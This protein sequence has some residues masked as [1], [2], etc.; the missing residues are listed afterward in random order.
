MLSTWMWTCMRLWMHPAPG[1]H[2]NCKFIRHDWWVMGDV[3]VVA[4]Q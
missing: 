3:L 4:Q 1:R 2:H